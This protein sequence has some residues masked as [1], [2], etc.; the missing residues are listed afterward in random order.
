[1]KNKKINTREIAVSGLVIA[2]YVVIMYF[3]QSFSFGQYQIRIATALYALAF[4]FPYL[5]LPLG[6]ANCLSNILG[7][8]PIDMIGGLI[9][10]LITAGIIALI[11]KHQGKE[12]LV[13]LPILLVP[14]LGVPVYLSKVIAVPYK[15]LAPSLLIGQIVPAIVGVLLIIVLKK[16]VENKIIK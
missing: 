3:T 15:I 7:G 4:L 8:S 2:L 12:F 16:Y 9:I 11:K 5:V 6:L 1:M 10:G 13:F 14:G